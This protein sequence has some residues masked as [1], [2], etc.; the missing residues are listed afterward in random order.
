MQCRS[1]NSRRTLHRMMPTGPYVYVNGYQGNTYQDQYGNQSI[2]NQVVYDNHSNN[3]CQASHWYDRNPTPTQLL[4][5]HSAKDIFDLTDADLDLLDYQDPSDHRLKAKP[6]FYPLDALTALADRSKVE[7]SELWEQLT[8]M[9]AIEQDNYHRECAERIEQWELT[10]LGYTEAPQLPLDIWITICEHLVDD[11]ELDDIR[12]PSTIARD[13]CSVSMTSKQLYAAN[14]SAFQ[15]LSM[16]CNAVE[17]EDSWGVLL[18]EPS[19]GNILSN[20][21]IESLSVASNLR[22]S[23][24]ESMVCGLY[25][26]IGIYKPIRVPA[27]LLLAVANEKTSFDLSFYSISQSS[28]LRQCKKTTFHFRAALSRLG[29]PNLH[30]FTWIMEQQQRM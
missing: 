20:R 28:A 11:L 9:Q 19:N 2:N 16:K 6:L 14:L 26:S 17:K 30:T 1:E 13:L 27:R 8:Y 18:T 21:T 22:I 5:T 24:R 12:G 4:P 7:R 10:P 25:N 29:F 23:T 3:S 15:K